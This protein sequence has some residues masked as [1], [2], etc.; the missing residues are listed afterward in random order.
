MHALGQIHINPRAEPD[1]SKAL[2]NIER[3]ALVNKTHNPAR[4]QSGNL[5]DTKPVRARIN[6][7]RIPLII[8]AGF[9]QIGIQKQPG[10][11]GD[12][13]NRSRNRHAVHMAI[14]HIHE[15]RNTNHRLI[16]Q[17]QLRRRHSARDHRHQTIRR[18]DH[19]PFPDWNRPGRIAEEI[20]APCRQDK[21]D[22]AERRPNPR[23][24]IG[25]HRKNS[26]KRPT[27]FVD[28]NNLLLDRGNE[29]HLYSVK[30][31]F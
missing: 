10:P 3:I 11:V 14:E 6:N 24:N 18:R 29:R 26:D 20:D 21:P 23:Q 27:L 12:P 5:H 13:V 30:I 31:S 28:G 25:N 8:L 19:K 2:A 4:D 16:R 7:Q 17:I 9:V 22:P 15:H 1:Q